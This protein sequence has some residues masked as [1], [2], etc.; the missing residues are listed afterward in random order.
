VDAAAVIDAPLPVVIERPSVAPLTRPADPRIGLCS[1]ADYPSNL[2]F[3]QEN[4]RIGSHEWVAATLSS[5]S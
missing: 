3:D 5:L 4:P 2:L 1:Q